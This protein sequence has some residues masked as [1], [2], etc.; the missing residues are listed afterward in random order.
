MLLIIVL[1]PQKGVFLKS[2]NRKIEKIDFFCACCVHTQKFLWDNSLML[3]CSPKN[4]SSFLRMF[5]PYKISIKKKSEKKG[6][7]P[8]FWK[9]NEKIKN[10]ADRPE[11]AKYF[12]GAKT[13]VLGGYTAWISFNLNYN[14]VLQSKT[15]EGGFFCSAR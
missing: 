12:W 15:R 13:R 1:M 2:K 9:K 4:F 14:W 5:L 8:E 7:P 3:C 6:L 10:L 11:S